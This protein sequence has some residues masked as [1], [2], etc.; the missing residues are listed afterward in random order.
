MTW[1]QRLRNGL[2]LS[3]KIWVP[4]TAVLL[5]MGY[6]FQIDLLQHS[7]LYVVMFGAVAI[8]AMTVVA[9]KN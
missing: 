7:T 5:L 9:K 1:K 6:F 4:V 3:L 8:T 2:L